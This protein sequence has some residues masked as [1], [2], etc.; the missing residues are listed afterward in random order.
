MMMYSFFEKGNIVDPVHGAN[1]TIPQ[2]FRL[3]KLRSGVD[4]TIY[5]TEMDKV[6]NKEPVVFEA[7]FKEHVAKYNNI[8]GSII[9]FPSGPKHVYRSAMLAYSP[10]TLKE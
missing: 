7:L 10:D 6:Y 9:N 3:Q 5:E 4:Y 1:D 8:S 2:E